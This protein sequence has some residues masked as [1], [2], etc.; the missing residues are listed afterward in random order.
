MTWYA[1]MRDHTLVKI[2]QLILQGDVR[3]TLKAELEM[4]EDGL[5]ETDVFAAI[6]NAQVINKRINSNNP[7][8]G[9]KETLCIIE[10]RSLYNELIYTKGKVDTDQFYV[11]ISSK[12]SQ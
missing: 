12:R 1:E 11:L 5:N 10:G 9:V 2:K 6:L 4:Y 3:F 7:R 8:T